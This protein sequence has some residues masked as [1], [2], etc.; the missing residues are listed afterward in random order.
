MCKCTLFR[1]LWEDEV[2]KRGTGFDVDTAAT[3]R[4][5]EVLRRARALHDTL[6][7]SAQGWSTQRM[8]V[9]TGVAAGGCSGATHTFKKKV[10]LA[11][12]RQ[13]FVILDVY[14]DTAYG[15][16]EYSKR[17]W[18]D[19]TESIGGQ[20]AYASAKKQKSMAT[21]KCYR[22]KGYGHFAADCPGKQA[23]ICIA[24]VHE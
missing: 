8:D 7:G 16:A 1:Q 15:G 5:E 23:R 10:P 17:K 24:A 22:C 13:L 14:Q 12:I 21:V 18:S 3:M 19:A 11:R 9:G 20:E 2:A 4:N 6:F